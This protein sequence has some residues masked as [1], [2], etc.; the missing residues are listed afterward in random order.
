M[1]SKEL[2]EQISVIALLAYAAGVA[3]G[4]LI[5]GVVL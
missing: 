2:V 3:T 1:K 5:F 4:F